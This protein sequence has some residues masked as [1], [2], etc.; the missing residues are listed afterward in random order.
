MFDLV[1]LR[2]AGRIVVDM[3]GEAGGVGELCSATAL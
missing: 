2:C 3:E 1:P